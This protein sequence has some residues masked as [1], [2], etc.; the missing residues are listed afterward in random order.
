M[1][2]PKK[3]SLL[4]TAILLLASAFS[5]A[6]AQEPAAAPAPSPAAPT[7]PDAPEPPPYSLDLPDLHPPANSG[8]FPNGPRQNPPPNSANGANRNQRSKFNTGGSKARG[9]S[10]DRVLQRAD[11][12]SLE[13]R[14]AYRRD[15]TQALARDPSLIELNHRAETAGTDDEKRLYLRQYYTHL[16]ASI[17]RL[18]SSAA[19]KAHL[20]LLSQVAAQ[21]YD[22]KRRAVAGEE[23]LLNGRDVGRGWLGR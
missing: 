21:Q 23:D 1:R 7:A 16:F 2:P 6:F 4:L 14:V 19:M 22:P 9:R 17:R 15:K 12:D 3:L 11:S 5:C 18:D 20:D 10:R 13:V 8:L